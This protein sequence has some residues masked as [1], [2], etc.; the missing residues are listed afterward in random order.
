MGRLVT[1]D[2][3]TLFNGVSRQPDVVRLP[4]QVEHADNTLLSVVTGGFSKRMHTEHLASLAG[5]SAATDYAVHTIFRSNTEQYLV[6]LSDG[7]IVIYNALTGAAETIAALAADATAYLAAGGAP[8]K[9]RFV[10]VG[11]TTYIVNNAVT[12][13]M[14]TGV[15]PGSLTGTRQTFDDLPVASGTGNIYRIRGDDSSGFSQYYVIDDAATNTWQEVARPGQVVQLN[16]T[17][18]PYALT[19]SG[20]TWTLQ[21]AVWPNRDVGDTT[22]VPRPNFI[23]RK[24][25]DIFYH[26]NRLGVLATDTVYPFRAGSATNVWPTSSV[27]VLDTDPFTLSAPSEH[28][29]TLAFAVT[30]RRALFVNAESDQFEVSSDGTFTPTNAAID[31]ATSYNA[32]TTARPT[33]M[34]DELYFAGNLSASSVLWEYFVDDDSVGST[35]VNVTKHV[36]GYLPSSIKTLTASAVAG[37]L[38]ALSTEDPTHVY[39]YSLFWDGSE[40][41]QSAWCRWA[42]GEDVIGM[43]VLEDWL[44]L[45]MD[46]GTAVTLERVAVDSL[47]NPE[48]LL[49]RRVSLTGA[50]DAGTGLTTWTIPYAHGSDGDLVLGELFTNEFGRILTITYASATTV[51]AVGDFSAH[52]AYFGYT[53]RMLVTLSRL[54][55]RE[56]TELPVQRGRLTLRDIVFSFKNSGFFEVRVTPI[57]RPTKVKQMTGRILGSSTNVVGAVNNI[58][59]EMTAGVRSNA[60]TV[61]IDIVNDS[62]WPCT[63]SSASWKGHFNEITRQE[64]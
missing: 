26:R 49:D 52:P 17:T 13:A 47:E 38:F 22:T 53:Y 56:R 35:A 48:P 28:S 45:V 63:I 43:A 58:S 40:K 62:I 7:G 21:A 27:L 54:Y 61:Q 9:F 64:P 41:I 10:T 60:A 46:R 37:R 19:K 39:V 30:F 42:F 31:L 5:A 6:L 15:A 57:G 44:Y 14:G 51:T 33:R 18:L 12:A 24:I 11:D 23:G 8:A 2:I 50:Y 32:N 3:N 25:Q 34:G 1:G 36:Q 20:G 4:S 29:P 59:G 55:Y 16:A